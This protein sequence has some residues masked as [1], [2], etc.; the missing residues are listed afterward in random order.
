MLRLSNDRLLE[1]E[2]I[3]GAVDEFGESGGPAAIRNLDTDPF[4][5]IQGSIYRQQPHSSHLNSLTR[6]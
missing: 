3:P 6:I 4:L 2:F 5:R 1:G